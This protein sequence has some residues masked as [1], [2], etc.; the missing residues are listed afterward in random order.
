VYR[1]LR[2]W[3]ENRGDSG[4]RAVKSLTGHPR[5]QKGESGGECWGSWHYLSKNRTKGTWQK[6]G[7]FSKSMT[8][9][10]KKKRYVGGN[11]LFNDCQGKRRG[12]KKIKKE[13]NRF[14]RQ[15][16]FLKKG[17]NPSR[18]VQSGIMRMN[19]SVRKRT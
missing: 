8:P 19:R 1:A 7:T 12:G 11:S 10:V 14:G 5:K 15:P 18:P 2:D 3:K 6:G 9:C 17:K 13:E 16:E 4:W